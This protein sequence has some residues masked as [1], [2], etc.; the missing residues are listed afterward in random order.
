MSE[1]R[2]RRRRRYQSPD[3]Q[4]LRPPV[5]QTSSGSALRPPDLGGETTAVSES[6]PRGETTA[7]SEL[8]QW[9]RPQ[10]SSGVRAQ[11]VAPPSDLQWCQSSDSGSALRP[12]VVTELRQWLRPQTS[13]GVRVQ[14]SSGVRVQ[15]SSGVR[16]RTVAPPSDLQWCQSSDLGGERYQSLDLQTSGGDEGGVRV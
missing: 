7:A 6:R 1:S 16:A 4:W 14:T 10:T 13:S 15:T 12:P 8:R 2:P 3:L 9:L 5:A 11:T